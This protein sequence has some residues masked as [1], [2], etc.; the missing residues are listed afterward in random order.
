MVEKPFY[1]IKKSF[2]L[3]FEKWLNQVANMD[4]ADDD[5]VAVAVLDTPLEA[6]AYSLCYTHFGCVNAHVALFI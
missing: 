6:L 4:V 2:F 3:C 1:E 5:L